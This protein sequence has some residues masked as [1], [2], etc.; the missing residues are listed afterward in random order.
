M[1]RYSPAHNKAT[2]KYQ[3]QAYD[4]ITVRVKKGERDLYSQKAA[5]HGF[6]SLNKCIYEYLKSL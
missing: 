2:Q 6:E 4:V 5:E 3:K 1:A